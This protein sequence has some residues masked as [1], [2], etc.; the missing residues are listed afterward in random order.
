M[1]EGT[2]ELHPAIHLHVKLGE[3]GE[4]RRRRVGGGRLPEPRQRGV[5]GGG[6][7]NQQLIQTL[8]SLLGQE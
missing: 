4:D 8:P 6:I 2:A 3:C 1:L 7:Y 5:V